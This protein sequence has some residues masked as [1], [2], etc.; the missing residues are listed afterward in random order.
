MA[1]RTGLVPVLAVAIAAALAPAAAA[2]GIH[3]LGE[4]AGAPAPHLLPFWL[5]FVA[6][7]KS[8]QRMTI[9]R[10]AGLRIFESDGLPDHA[11]GRFPNRNNPNSIA[12]QPTLLP[13][14]PADRARMRLWLKRIDDPV[15]PSTGVLTHATAFR[16]SFLAKS[17]EEQKAHMEK[18]PDLARRARQE[19]VYREGLDSPIVAGAVRVFDKLLNDME[20][21]LAH[22]DFI[23]GP[24]YSLA[25]AAATPYLNRLNDLTLLRVWADTCPRVMA[26]YDHI[27]ARPSFKAAVTDYW[28]DADAVHFK[29][30][31]ADTADRARAIL[32]A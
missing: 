20:A 24:A 31:A 19:S 4:T 10:A 27:R 11:T 15:H 26:W 6:P 32:A 3:E 16:A 25:D 9:D 29:G 14:A 23:A 30:V 2:H 21:A 28:T 12:P 1:A 18:M 8:A 17:P 5:R 7:A 13:A 22:G